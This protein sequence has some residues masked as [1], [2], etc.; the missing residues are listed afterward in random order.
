M[1]RSGIREGK[2]EAAGA[3][4]PAET[5]ARSARSWSTG[6]RTKDQIAEKE[7]WG[8]LTMRGSVGQKGTWVG[9]SYVQEEN[10]TLL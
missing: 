10:W 1:A 4:A 5:D 9:S 2:N 6:K 3:L 8:P 7:N